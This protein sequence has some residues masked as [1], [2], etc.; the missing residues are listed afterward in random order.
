MTKTI[1]HYEVVIKVEDRATARLLK[2]R[3]ERYGETEIRVIKKDKTIEKEETPFERLMRLNKETERMIEE[4]KKEV[5][6]TEKKFEALK[7][8]KT[9][10]FHVPKSI[11]FADDDN[12]C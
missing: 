9:H 10:E 5:E 11:V 12:P 8:A 3:F 7:E 4:L 6:E 1:D 2:K